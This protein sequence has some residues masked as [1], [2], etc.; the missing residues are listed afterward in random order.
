MYKYVIFYNYAKRGVER[1]HL[2][3]NV[4]KI[5]RCVENREREIDLEMAFLSIEYNL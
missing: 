5:G 1:R 4:S 3:C 2:I